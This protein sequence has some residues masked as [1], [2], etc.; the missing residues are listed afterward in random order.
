MTRMTTTPATLAVNADYADALLTA[1][2]AKS[3]LFLLLLLIL[4]AQIAMF[5]VVRF[6]D[7]IPVYD[8]G[9]GSTVVTAGPGGI[10]ATSTAGPTTDA[11]ATQPAVSAEATTQPARSVTL[12][13]D[14]DTLRAVL[15]YA[16]DLTV[17]LGVTLGLVMLVAVFLMM[18]IMLVGRLLGVTHVTSAVVWAALLMVFL[19]PWQV[20]FNR[21]DDAIAAVSPTPGDAVLTDAPAGAATVST[22]PD[23]Y[24]PGVLY[25]WSELVRDARFDADDDLM[26]AIL[27]YARFVGFPLLAVILLVIVQ[28]KSSRG[29]RFALGEADVQ[30][31]VA[32]PTT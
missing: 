16:V 22:A 14:N 29:A 28:T 27:K 8:R 6:S 26:V 12:R 20:F 18:M 11:G 23:F 4:L 1:R 2:R 24:L 7:A 17:F 19:F 3:T 30:V 13:A 31:E 21:A 25:T 15:K 10:D 9:G 32:S 5:F